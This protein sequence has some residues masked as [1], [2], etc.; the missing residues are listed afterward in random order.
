MEHQPGVM[1]IRGALAR[2]HVDLRSTTLGTPARGH[3]DLRSTTLGTLARGH[4]DLRSTTLGTPARGHVDLRSTTLGTLARGHVDLRSTTLGT[5]ARGHVDKGCKIMKL[6]SGSLYFVFLTT[7]S[8]SGVFR[9]VKDFSTGRGGRL[10]IPTCFK[11]VLTVQ[12]VASASAT[13]P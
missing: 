3:V 1:W 7:S 6:T 13:S 8:S 11:L 5:P 12:V 4:V 9:L 10:V 2:G